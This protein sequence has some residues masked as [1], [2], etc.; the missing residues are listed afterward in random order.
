MSTDRRH[1]LPGQI[2][3]MQAGPGRMMGEPLNGAQAIAFAQQRQDFQYGR[4]FAAHRLKERAGLRAEGMLARPAIQAPLAMRVHPN[5]ARIHLA[6]ITTLCLPTPLTFDFHRASPPALPMIRQAA[7]PG[8]GH[9]SLSFPAKV[10]S[11]QIRTLFKMYQFDPDWTAPSR[12]DSNPM[13]WYLSVS[14]PDTFMNN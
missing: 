8:L 9:H 5:I 2:Q 4:S 12:V 1:M 7:F 3:P 14:L 10:T 13:I 11:T 6:K